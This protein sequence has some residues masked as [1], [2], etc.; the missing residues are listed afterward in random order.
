MIPSKVKWVDALHEARKSEFP[1][2]EE[3]EVMNWEK[4]RNI[5]RSITKNYRNEKTHKRF[6]NFIQE[7]QAMWRVSQEN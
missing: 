5:L 1:H 4:I 7:A 6:I 3:L 2:C